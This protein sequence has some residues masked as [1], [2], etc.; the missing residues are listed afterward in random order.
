MA[1]LLYGAEVWLVSADMQRELS[2][3]YRRWVRCM[4][5]VNLRHTRKHHITAHELEKKLGLEDIQ[6]YVDQRV[7]GW[8]GHVARMT[9]KR[10]PRCLLTSYADTPRR[11]GGQHLTYGKMLWKALERKEM[12]KDWMTLALD[13]TNWRKQSQ[14]SRSLNIDSQKPKPKW[15]NCPHLA[16]STRV[17]KIIG[18]KWMLGMVSKFLTDEAT[19]DYRWE[20]IYDNEVKESYGRHELMKLM[21]PEDD[22]LEW[23]T[24]Q[25]AR[26][27][28]LIGYRF[29]KGF[30]GQI[31][32]GTI[33]SHDE[34]AQNH[35]VIWRV[36]YDDDDAAD[37]NIAEIKEGIRMMKNEVDDDTTIQEDK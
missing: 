20:V 19:G 16:L 36:T 37:Y 35:E 21:I 27:S 33:T 2:A 8:A 34:D 7:L 9:E 10:L 12:K 15:H 3:A 26:P 24:Q 25:L 13:K 22:P 4:A 31:F 11:R 5:R 17:E 28:K 14:R 23:T 1:M 6:F 30:D 18:T 29:A 32:H